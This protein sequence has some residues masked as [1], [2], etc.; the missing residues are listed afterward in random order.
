MNTIKKGDVIVISA[1][2][3][4]WI[5]FQELISLETVTPEDMKSKQALFKAAE[6]NKRPSKLSTWFLVPR[7][8]F[9]VEHLPAKPNSIDLRC[10]GMSKHIAARVEKLGYYWELRFSHVSPHSRKKK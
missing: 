6:T 5:I 8:L 2:Y 7:E 1:L 3:G 4:E 9:Y 10:E